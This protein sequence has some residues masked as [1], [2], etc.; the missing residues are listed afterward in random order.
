MRYGEYVPNAPSTFWS[1][2]LTEF[3]YT[4]IPSLES[5]KEELYRNSNFARFVKLGLKR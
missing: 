1:A 5:L 3:Q 4:I 2:F